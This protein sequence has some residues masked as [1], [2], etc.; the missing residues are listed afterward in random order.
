MCGR[1]AQPQTK[2]E[3]ARRFAVAD[4][5]AAPELAPSFNLPPSRPAYVVGYNHHARRRGLAAMSW[6]FVPRW[7]KKS[8]REAARPINAT[9][10]GVAEKPTFRD[11]FRSRRCLVPVAGFF[12]WEKRSGTKVPHWLH[13]AD[14]GAFALAG[15]WNYWPPE[16]L[17]SFA[18]VTTTPNEL[19]RP[20]HDRMPVILPEEQWGEWLDPRTPLDAVRSLLV[21]FPAERMRAFP[22]SR[23][24]NSPK[25]DGPE[26]VTPAA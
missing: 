12:E 19:V 8:L 11:S 4:A 6:G 7:W 23:L 17:H 15:V 9:A 16:K 26:L 1:F 22:V 3:L 20:L 5:T 10:E 2:D 13:P 24:V 25:N 18:V 14:D 21:P